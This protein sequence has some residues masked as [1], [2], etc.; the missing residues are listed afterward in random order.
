MADVAQQTTTQQTTTQQTSN[1]TA[2]TAQATARSERGNR[3]KIEGIVK[4]NKMLKTIT[5][6]VSYLQKHAKYGKYMKKYTKFYAH[7]EKGEAK[8]G[9]LVEIC[10]TRPLS[11]LKR[12]RLLRVIRKAEQ[13]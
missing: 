13:I 8:P 3:R 1:S 11:R 9:D 2:E 5:V 6:E 7:D 12:H 10:E 4:S